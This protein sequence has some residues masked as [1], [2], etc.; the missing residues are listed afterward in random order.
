MSLSVMFFMFLFENI[1]VSSFI[2]DD[3]KWASGAM[4][5]V[6]VAAVE[7]AEGAATEKTASSGVD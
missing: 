1:S 6:A 2:L 4:L 3:R 5:E 7:V